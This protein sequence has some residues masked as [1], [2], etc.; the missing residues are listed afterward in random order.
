LGQYRADNFQIIQH[1]ISD[2][3]IFVTLDEHLG[4]WAVLP[5]REHCGV[6]R[7][8]VHPATHENALTTLLPFSKT[9]LNEIF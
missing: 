9:V 7:L 2:A 1:A 8:K 4:D 6:I 5:L 3:R